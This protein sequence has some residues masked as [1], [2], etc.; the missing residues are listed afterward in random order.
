MERDSKTTPLKTL[1]GHMWREAYA[2]GEIQG[3]YVTPDIVCVYRKWANLKS[4]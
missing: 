4:S 2:N 1:Q 3:Q